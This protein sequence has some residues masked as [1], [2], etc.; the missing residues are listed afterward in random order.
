VTKA[1]RN[2]ESEVKKYIVQK[3]LITILNKKIAA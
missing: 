1:G 2:L 3:R